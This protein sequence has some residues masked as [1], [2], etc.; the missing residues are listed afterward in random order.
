MHT[1]F[2]AERPNFTWYIT[3]MGSGLF[4]G[5]QSRPH[6]QMDG[7]AELPNFGGSFLFMHTPFATELPKLTW[8]HMWCRQCILGLVTPPI[9]RERSS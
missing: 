3:D 9:P 8:L 7:I 2:D 5:G 4:L 6:H 1:P